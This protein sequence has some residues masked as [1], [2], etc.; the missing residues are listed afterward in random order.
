MDDVPV[1]RM[2]ER[3]LDGIGISPSKM[4][5]YSTL[6]PWVKK[7]GVITGIR[8]VTRPYSLRYGAGTALDSSGEWPWA[9]LWSQW[10][11]RPSGSVS[12]S[13]R[14]LVMHNAD[15]RTFLKFYL[16][17]RINKNLPAII[18]G[19]DPEEDIMR[20]ACRMSRTIDP[21]RPQELTTEQSS[22]VNC[23]SQ[24]ADLIRR[25]DDISHDL[26]RPLS[27]HKGTTKIR[28]VQE[29]E[30]GVSRSQE[31]RT[32]H[33]TRTDSKQIWPRAANA[34]DKAPI[35]RFSAGEVSD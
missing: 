23:Q 30:P 6:E 21:D 34:R 17:R 8:Q 14:N 7:I 10:T 31:A 15:T 35:I 5:P 18:R 24:I 2:S 22:S 12:D 28:D 20:A 25:R 19:L 16:S 1:F 27:R 33:A 32:K 4:L 13:L 29:T 3:T 11:K 9:F 26:G